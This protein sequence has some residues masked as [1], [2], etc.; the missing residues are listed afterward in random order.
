MLLVVLTMVLVLCCTNV[1]AGET[2]IDNIM[3][4]IKEL[5][6]PEVQNLMLWAKGY[7]IVDNIL[8]E[9]EVKIKDVGTGSYI[10]ERKSI[11]VVASSCNTADR[12]MLHELTH[13]LIRYEYKNKF[14]SFNDVKEK[15][16]EKFAM[17]SKLFVWPFSLKFRS[18]LF[19]KAMAERSMM[20]AHVRSVIPEGFA[21]SGVPSEKDDL[22]HADALHFHE[23]GFVHYLT[24][25]YEKDKYHRATAFGMFLRNK[26]VPMDIVAPI[27]ERLRELEQPKTIVTG[28]DA[29]TWR[30]RRDY[31]EYVP[32]HIIKQ[33]DELGM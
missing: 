21:W 33:L 19:N 12:T 15:E 5:I 30:L 13:A 29:D 3:E 20:I 6:S 23:E 28:G 10:P 11:A 26:G 4:A 16:I 24:E 14:A 32:E 18:P 7:G 22:R 27:V 31:G 8:L 1:R 17:P 9:K 25:P 2:N